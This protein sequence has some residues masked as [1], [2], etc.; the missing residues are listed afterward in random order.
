MYYLLWQQN[1]I[2]N[3]HTYHTLYD[4]CHAELTMYCLSILGNPKAARIIAFEALLELMK[5]LDLKKDKNPDAWIINLVAQ[6]CYQHR[7]RA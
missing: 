4:K 2:S 6:K 7:A 3:W 1:K 5:H